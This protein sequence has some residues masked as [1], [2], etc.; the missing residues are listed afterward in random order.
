MYVWTS[1]EEEGAY[2]HTLHTEGEK[3]CNVY[4]IGGM[5]G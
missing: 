4:V 5:I 1:M 3:E 2:P